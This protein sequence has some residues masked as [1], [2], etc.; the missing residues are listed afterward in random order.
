MWAHTIEME[1]ARLLQQW[2]P[3]PCCEG[4]LPT[5]GDAEE[6]ASGTLEV[7]SVSANTAGQWHALIVV[8]F[9]QHRR[10]LTRSKCRLFWPTPQASGT[11]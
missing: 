11:L 3:L 9:G 4:L 1:G 10:P 7:S 6:L 5:G 2:L 8:C